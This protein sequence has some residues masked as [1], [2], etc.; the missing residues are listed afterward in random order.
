MLGLKVTPFDGGLRVKMDARPYRFILTQ[1]PAEDISAAGWLVADAAAFDAYK[2]HLSGLNVPFEDASAE[3]ITSRGVE[4]LLRVRDPNGL[5]HEIYVDKAGAEEPFEPTLTKGGFVIGPGGLGHIVFGSKDYEGSIAFAEDVL[6]ARVSDVI[7]Q[8]I[9]PQVTANVTFLHVNQRHHSI[10]F[11]ARAG[12][13]KLHHFM[14]EVERVDDVGRA[15]DRHLAFGLPV[16]Q[17]I[18]Q[19][20]NDQM[21]SYYGVTPSGFLVEY[22]WGGVKVDV[23]AW[24]PGFYDRMSEWG[25]R[26]AAMPVKPAPPTQPKETP[27]SVAG[28]WK[29]TINT[30]MGEQ[31]GDLSIKDDLTGKVT[32]M[33]MPIDIYGAALDGDKLSF[34]ADATLPFPMT[35]AFALTVAGDAI[36]GEVQAGAFGASPVR[37]ERA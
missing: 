7:K 13:K 25:H 8:V 6:G 22:G 17:D 12:A 16:V 29:L 3:E 15:R 28:D 36:S 26:P 19:H 4:Q 37:G 31:K 21:I 34:K 33:G 18:G 2:T 35:L 32:S 27:M 30:P 1:G 9:N 10:A 14:I 24:T 5:A 11:A 23:D 20:P